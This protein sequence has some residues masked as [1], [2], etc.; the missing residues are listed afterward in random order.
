[1]KNLRLEI[2]KVEFCNSEKNNTHKT[3]YLPNERNIQ[4]FSGGTMSQQSKWMRSKKLAAHIGFWI[5]TLTVSD[6]GIT[7]CQAQWFP[8]YEKRKTALPIGD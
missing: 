3:I 5:I 1:M 6:R 8:Y 4:V 2:G 7:E